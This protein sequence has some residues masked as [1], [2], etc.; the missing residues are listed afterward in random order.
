MY[1]PHVALWTIY[2]QAQW[3]QREEQKKQVY[4]PR[5]ALWTIT[6]LNGIKEKSRRNKCIYQAQW[7]QREEQKKQEYLPHVALWNITKLNGITWFF[8]IYQK[9]QNMS[10]SICTRQVEASPTKKLLTTQ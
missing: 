5:V 8:S 1:W 3:H 9:L 10:L 2:H 6:K 7:Y 4:L